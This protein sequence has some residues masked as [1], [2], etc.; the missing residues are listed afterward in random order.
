MRGM[1]AR[2]IMLLIALMVAIVLS[3]VYTPEAFADMGAKIAVEYNIHPLAAFIAMEKGIFAK[4]GVYIESFKVY[5]TGLQITSALV[6]GDADVAFICLSPAILAYARRARIK[7][8]CLTHLYG[9]ALVASPRIKKVRDLNG[10]LVGTMKMGS[11]LDL[12]YQMVKRKYGLIVRLRRMSPLRQ[13]IAL[14]KGDLKAAFL[15]EPFAEMAVERGFHYLLKAKDIWP[16]MNGSVLVARED[17]I[18]KYPRVINGLVKSLR[19]ANTLIYR[20]PLEA[21]RCAQK[22][23]GVPAKTVVK[24]LNDIV[25]TTKIDISQIRKT[26]LLMKELGYIPRNLEVDKILLSGEN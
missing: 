13:L 10:E 2:K 23:I 17:Y 14:T 4:N 15:S 19:E 18:R 24:A 22:Y 21:G 1:H 7:I 11:P 9:Y 8:V 26:A 16:G 20:N 12:L 6:R 5:R 3:A 25:Y